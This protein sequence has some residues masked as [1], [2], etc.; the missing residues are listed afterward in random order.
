MEESKSE[1]TIDEGALFKLITEGQWEDVIVSMTS[2]M[3]PWDIDIVRLNERFMGV[4]KKTSKMDLKVPA[5]IILTAAILYRMKVDTLHTIEQEEEIDSFEEMEEE[6][7]NNLDDI[8][9]EGIDIPPLAMPIKRAPKGK[10]SM[11]DLVG[12]LEKAMTIKNRRTAREVFSIELAGEDITHLIEKLFENISQLIE[13]NPKAR[14][15]YFV[16]D[17]ELKQKIQTFNS[18]LHL[19]NQQ[20]VYC[21]QPE[22][23]GEIYLYGGVYGDANTGQ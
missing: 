23:F 6:P 21:Y 19:S 17:K 18:L 1:L 9:S 14:F 8:S 7:I 12:A 13:A 11:D 4:I 10:V 16:N 3:D 2:D 22:I 5:K 15:S 20:R